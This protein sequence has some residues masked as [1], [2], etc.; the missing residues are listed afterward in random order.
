[1]LSRTSDSPGLS[2]VGDA[3]RLQLA[4]AQLLLIFT[5]DLL[6]PSPE[7]GLSALEACLPFVDIVQVR[8]KRIEAPQTGQGPVTQKSPVTRASD[9]LQLCRAV[10]DAVAR[11]EST[12][13]PLVIVND[14]VD[15]AAALLGDANAPG[16]DGVHVGDGDTP[17][18]IARRLLGPDALIGLST[19]TA[20]DLARSMDEPVDMLGFGPIFP[21]ATKGYGMTADAVASP[22]RAHAPRNEPRIVGPEAAWIAAES[23]AIPLFPIGGIDHSNADQLD[24]IGRAAVGSAILKS[25]D[26]GHAASSLRS[27]LAE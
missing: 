17:P 12:A 8:P 21:T 7:L 14:R 9:A 20:R 25:K 11:L 26:P 2:P 10:L 6:G 23:V 19:H 18:E 5:P 27:L 24:R 22:D 16:V 13:R 1:M 3:R 15:V 4:R